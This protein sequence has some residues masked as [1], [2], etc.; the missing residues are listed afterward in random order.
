MR[1][2][3]L[4]IKR[5]GGDPLEFCK[6]VRQFTAKI[7]MNSESEDAK[8]HSN[9][10]QVSLLD[11]HTCLFLNFGFHVYHVCHVNQCKSDQEQKSEINETYVVG[12]NPTVQDFQP[13]FKRNFF[14]SARNEATTKLHQ[15]NSAMPVVIVSSSCSI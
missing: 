13:R 14:L 12:L 6:F 8:M 11:V 7:V 3:N 9:F 15:Q 10:H 4:D 1:K 2:P 5:F